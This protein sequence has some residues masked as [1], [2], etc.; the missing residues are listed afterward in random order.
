M[1]YVCTKKYKILCKEDC[2]H[3]KNMKEENMIWFDTVKEGFEY[4]CR[5][6]KHCMPSEE[7]DK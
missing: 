7:D 1:K 2:F 4:G 5:P 3:V 6:C